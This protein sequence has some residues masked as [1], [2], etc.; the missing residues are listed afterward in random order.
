MTQLLYI[1][2]PDMPKA[3]EIARTLLEERLIACANIV[4][5]IESVY[6]WEGKVCESSEA[7]LLAKTTQDKI[8][9]VVERVKSLHDY[10]LPAIVA[11]PISGGLSAF[12]DWVAA[13]VR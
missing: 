8:P 5:R 12:L 13:E 1:T 4:P 10:E 7:L 11:L 9:Q 3:R 2:V 6:R